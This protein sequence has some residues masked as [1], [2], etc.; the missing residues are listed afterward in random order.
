MAGSKKTRSLPAF[1]VSGTS[2][3]SGKTLAA[4]GIMEALRRRGLVVQPFKAGPDYIDPG[5]HSLLLGRPSYNLD[6]WMMGVKGVQDTFCRASVG[7]DCAVVEGVMGLFDGRGGEKEAG[8]TAHLSKA[9]GLPVVL[10]ANAEKA[11]QSMG[12][13]VKG[14]ETYDKSV[15]LKW[16]IFNK[17]ASP[18]HEKILRDSVR[19]SKVKVLGCIPR[20]SAL[21]MESRHLGLVTAAEM[22]GGWIDFVKRAGDVIEESINLDSLLRSSKTAVKTAP[23]RPVPSARVRVAVA[24]DRAFSFYYRENLD[25]LTASGAELVPFSPLSDKALPGR[26]GGIYIGGGYPELHAKALEDNRF[27]RDEIRRAS[28]SGMPVYAECGGLMYLGKT[29][30]SDGK[31]RRMAGVFPWTTR[32]LPKRKALGYREAALTG[33]CPFLK[34]GRIRGHEFHYSD[35]STDAGA[36]TAYRVSGADADFSEGFVFRRVL[37]SYIHLHFASNPAFAAGFVKASEEFSRRK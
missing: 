35:M 13:V 30:E 3:G 31:P 15:D 23:I 2:S 11:A 6:T 16:V 37:A 24:M 20:D 28:E 18:R 5:L 17:V 14:F 26:I 21:T 19:G 29:I 10:V 36:G 22:G 27:L 12:A 9:L 34:K 25:I 33:N 7:S 8:S 4:L 1:V 32:L